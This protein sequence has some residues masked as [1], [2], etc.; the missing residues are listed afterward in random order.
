MG[1]MTYSLSDTL[2]IFVEHEKR[3]FRQARRVTE[4][5]EFPR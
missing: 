4:M 3:H 1:L 5:Q 2:K